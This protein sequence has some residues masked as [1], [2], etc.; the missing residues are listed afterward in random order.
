M[1]APALAAAGLLFGLA[2]AAHCAAMCGAFAVQAA[3]ARRA[4]AGTRLLLYTSGKAFTYASLGALAGAAGGACVAF[5]GRWGAALAVLVGGA[6]VAAGAGTL[7]GK[8]AAAG[9][10]GF[11]AV[12]LGWLGPLLAPLRNFGG[13][14]GSFA[15][16]LATGLLP[17]G[18][19]ALALL[20]AATLGAPAES[21]LFMAAFGLGTAPVLVATGLLSRMVGARLSTRA[22]RIAGGAVL[23]VAGGLALARG[24]PL[25]LDPD[26]EASAPACPACALVPGHHGAPAAASPARD[27]PPGAGRAQDPAQSAAA[28]DP[29]P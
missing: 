13:S 27:V 1:N 15:L 11:G 17:C 18:V 8:R 23:L 10:A 26:R 29:P 24:V 12:A 4:F 6:L 22:L 19:T 21:A 9:R 5:A 20:Q 28:G 14:S 25:L 2:N 16:G 7:L 3:G